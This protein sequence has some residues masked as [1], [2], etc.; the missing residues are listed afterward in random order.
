MYTHMYTQ[1]RTLAH[2]RPDVRMDVFYNGLFF[3]PFTNALHYHSLNPYH[4][5]KARWQLSLY[6][7][8]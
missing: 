7:W 3:Q 6:V 1:A 8:N 2:M 4:H 5:H